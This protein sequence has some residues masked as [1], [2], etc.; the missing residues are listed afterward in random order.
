MIIKS[1]CS[2][3]YFLILIFLFAYSNK[4]NNKML[5]LI[6][7]N[8]LGFTK[9]KCNCGLSINK[10]LKKYRKS[11]TNKSGKNRKHKK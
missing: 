7:K 11:K 3:I 5:T 6:S 4:N 10:N 2:F 1:T 9:P 8:D